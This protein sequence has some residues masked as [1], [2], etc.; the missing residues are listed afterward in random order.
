MNYIGFK[1]NSDDPTSGKIVRQGVAPRLPPNT[2]EVTYMEYPHK[3]E[4][5]VVKGVPMVVPDA[6]LQWEKVRARRAD[7]LR[8]TDWARS[9]DV[10]PIVRNAYL[11]YRQA[12]RDL[13]ANTADPFNVV[14][15]EPPSTAAFSYS[16]ATLEEAKTYAAGILLKNMNQFIEVESDGTIRYDANFKFS[17]LVFGLKKG[18]SAAPGPTLLTWMG[19]VAT[20]YFT[21]DAQIKACT[22]VADIQAIDI[23]VAGFEAK[24]GKSG[25]MLADPGITTEQLM[26]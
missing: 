3:G 7:L 13:P 8:E 14:W 24:F 26:S 25:T 9:D 6:N 11:T 23:S 2:A 17:A 19:A 20:E 18:L 10:N 12:L 5:D 16:T 21:I 22:T 4:T 1:P 15:P